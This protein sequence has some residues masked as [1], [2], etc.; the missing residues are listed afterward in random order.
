MNIKMGI[1]KN[2]MIGGLVGILAFAGTGLVRRAF[3]DNLP[4][5]IVPKNGLVISERRFYH[6]GIPNGSEIK[7]TASSPTKTAL[8]LEDNEGNSN[9]YIFYPTYSPTDP[10]HPIRAFAEAAGQVYDPNTMKLGQLTFSGDAHDPSF[11]YFLY[12]DDGKIG[13][14]TGLVYADE[15]DIYVSNLEN[16]PDKIPK[17]RASR[18]GVASMPVMGYPY[19]VFK[20]DN[21]DGTNAIEIHNHVEELSSRVTVT[22]KK[23]GSVDIGNDG[24]SPYVFWTQLDEEYT[25]DDPNRLH[26]KLDGGNWNVYGW[27]LETKTTKILENDP[28]IS[29][30]VLSVHGNKVVFP[31]N[32]FGDRSD[33]DVFYIKQKHHRTSQGFSHGRI[34]GINLDRNT[35]VFDW[36]NLDGTLKNVHGLYITPESCESFSIIREDNLGK[37]N[38]YASSCFAGNTEFS[39][40][41]ST[42]KPE[43][44]GAYFFSAIMPEKKLF[45]PNDLWD[46]PRAFMAYTEPVVEAGVGL[47]DFVSW[48]MGPYDDPNDFETIFKPV[49][50]D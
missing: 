11:Q 26:L 2:L 48:S 21:S 1:G 47:E 50:T 45:D 15:G 17:S 3:S 13:V 29:C 33:I 16:L 41:N 7:K 31:M 30:P 10:N 20:V 32:Q 23:I 34:T 28:N 22:D 5:K 36:E 37:G 19:F 27:D 35:L 44:S 49:F 40:P 8:E 42:L 14:H 25:G 39:D 38:L 12:D 24:T 9:I 43:D 18:G 46:E 4:Y 6:F